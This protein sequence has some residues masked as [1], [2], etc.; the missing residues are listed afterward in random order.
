MLIKY[1]MEY[2]DL[3]VKKKFIINPKTDSELFVEGF[4]PEKLFKLLKLYF[5]N[6]TL[7]FSKCIA[8][9]NR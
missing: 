8:N 7:S 5:I 4:A 6:L 9:S 2:C 1:L 3:Q